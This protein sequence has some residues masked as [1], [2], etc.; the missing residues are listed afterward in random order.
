[1]LLDTLVTFCRFFAERDQ[2]FT[3]K[4]GLLQ[5]AQQEQ[6]HVGVEVLDH[7]LFVSIGPLLAWAGFRIKTRN[8]PTDYSRLLLP[9]PDGA[10]G[11]EDQVTRRDQCGMLGTLVGNGYRPKLS[12]NSAKS[13]T[14][15]SGLNGVSS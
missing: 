14:S 13:L 6:C 8:A 1:M 5:Q 10:I 12:A 4:A 15:M 9:L 2:R 11:T 3:E 7:Q